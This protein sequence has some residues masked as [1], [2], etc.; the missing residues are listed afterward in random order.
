MAPENPTITHISRTSAPSNS[1]SRTEATMDALENFIANKKLQPGDS[2]PT[3][4]ELVAHLG[5]SRSSVREGLR[6]LQAL[7]IINVQQGKGA[8]VG[9]MSLRPFI[10]SILLRCSIAPNS[11]QA[12]RQVISLRRI[13]DQGI[14]HELLVHFHGTHNPEL[15]ALV[16]T[17][18]QRAAHGEVFTD[19]DIAFHRGLI[20]SIDNLLVE[21]LV[22][23]MWEVHTIASQNL[24]HS[25]SD[26]LERTAKAHR[27]ILTALEAGDAEA[28]M[29]AV[30]EH[31]APL[32][33][34]IDG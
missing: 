18:E 11:L 25:S 13:L 27:S 20:H 6:Q 32:E 2:L 29:A 5:V 12:L 3:E 22:S 1:L 30:D 24:A 19:E 9:D 15:H 31:Y 10:K 17:M 33:R 4:A 26:S 21:Q 16:D 23:A 28:Y 7:D 14:A 34:I 8:F